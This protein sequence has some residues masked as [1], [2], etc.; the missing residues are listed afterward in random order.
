MNEIFLEIASYVN[1]YE[2]SLVLSDL[3]IIYNVDEITRRKV[4]LIINENLNW[5]DTHSGD[6]RN[7]LNDFHGSSGSLEI[8][9]NFLIILSML[10]SLIFI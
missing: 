7:F 3:L 4:R 6:I 1:N 5:I 2:M 10:T 8:V 9:F